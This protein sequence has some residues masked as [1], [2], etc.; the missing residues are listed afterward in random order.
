MLVRLNDIST[1]IRC[2]AM[3]FHTDIHDSRRIYPDSSDISSN[4]AM[5][6]TFYV[7]SEVL[8]Q[9]LD[10]LPLNLV[11]LQMSFIPR[12]R[13]VLTLVDAPQNLVHT[14]ALI[15]EQT[16]ITLVI[17]FTLHRTNHRSQ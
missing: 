1:T 17:P 3:K 15:L 4:S 9:L 14:F 5:R 6:L 2:I 8:K 16:V 10:N 7:L 13:I 11:G 12:G